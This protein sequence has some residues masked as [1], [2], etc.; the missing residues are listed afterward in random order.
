MVPPAGFGSAE[1]GVATVGGSLPTET[2][3]V[4]EMP[5]S[6]I[7]VTVKTPVVKPA[8]NR[9]VASIEFSSPSTDQMNVAAA[10]ALPN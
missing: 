9:P 7:A 2:P 4:P 1:A 8:V 6:L 10:L 5:S 3:A